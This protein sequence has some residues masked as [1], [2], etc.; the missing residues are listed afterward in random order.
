[1]IKGLKIQ[2]AT[3]IIGSVISFIASAYYWF[4]NNETYHRLLI[5]GL[6][7]PIMEPWMV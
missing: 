1:M 7:L 5:I 6:V 3:S 2:I 4:N